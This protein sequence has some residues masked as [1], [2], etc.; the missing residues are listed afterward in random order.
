MGLHAARGIF[1]DLT[2]DD[3]F[4]LETKR[5]WLRWPRT[6]DAGPITSFA[7]LADTAQMTAAI[8]HPYPAGEAERFIFEARADNANGKSLVLAITPKR[9][10]HHTIGVISA[11]QSDR[12]KIE[13][14][15]LLAPHAWGKGFAT[16]AAR[17]LVDAVFALTSA[18]T[19]VAN[20][21][22]INI[23]SRRVL[24]KCGFAYTDTGLDDLPARGGLYPCDRFALE[25]ADWARGRV[26]SMPP[27]R[28]QQADAFG[29]AAFA[30]WP[31]C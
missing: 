27:M 8:P 31:D 18:T 12:S 24:E 10:T 17:A 3:I 1:P 11:T 7:S 14:G 6:S 23:A 30:A 29:V 19:V 16:E 9:A 28:H 13:L 20:A 25:R 2:S 15:Y 22:V 21:R 5:L 4:R 26:G